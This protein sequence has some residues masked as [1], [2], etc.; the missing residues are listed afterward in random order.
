MASAYATADVSNASLHSIFD[1]PDLAA[2]I[3]SN[4]CSAETVCS[5]AAVASCFT[6]PCLDE[7]VWRR[8]HEL[9]W[10]PT[11]QSASG[12]AADPSSW[13]DEYRRR[14]SKDRQAVECIRQL[15]NEQKRDGAWERLQRLGEEVLGRIALLCTHDVP[16][17]AEDDAQRAEA[18]IAIV[19]INQ[20]ATIEA[21][22]SLMER[23]SR[24]GAAGG[25]GG[26]RRQG[27]PLAVEEGA[28]LI[29]RLYQTAAQ[30]VRQHAPAAAASRRRQQ[31]AC[32]DADDESSPA[33]GVR[34]ELDSL[35]A[36]LR[37]R[38]AT[39]DGEAGDGGSGGGGGGGSGG[40]GGGG[41]GGGNG[42]GNG[43]GGEGGAEGAA[44]A[45]A[46]VSALKALLFT[47]E[48]LRGADQGDYYNHENSLLDRVLRSRRGIPISLSCIFAAVCHR[49]G[50]ELDMIGLPGHFLLATRPPPAGRA[51]RIFIDAFHGGELLQ[52]SQCENIVRS[53]GYRW[54]EDM[55]APVPPAEVC[56]RMLRNLLNAHKQDGDMARARIVEAALAATSRGRTPALPYPGKPRARP[57]GEDGADGDAASEV[58][59]AL[60]LD[61]SGASL[62]PQQQH[63][64]MQMLMQQMQ[65]QQ[66]AASAAAEGQG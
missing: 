35:A 9:R 40:G 42:G 50:V 15:R 33:D 4:H 19:G 32:E 29:V 12:L 66:A 11:P 37:A 54:S 59:R 23:E 60:S 10:A 31:A 57:A 61:P 18:E 16:G 36:R 44:D 34:A 27:Q 6:Q 43:G 45:V 26:P 58:R 51:E 28:L 20:R 62:T 13:R 25:A 2:E 5:L 55:A 38:L 22:V 49:I 48:G 7:A 56:Q 1:L 24:G 39:A 41:G 17:G 63:Q 3:L 64:L 8:Q 46:A 52:L 21:W 30:L 53:Y 65:L 14:H 47:E